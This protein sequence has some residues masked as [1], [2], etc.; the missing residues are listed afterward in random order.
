MREFPD[1][2]T[3]IHPKIHYQREIPLF[4]V[5]STSIG[6]FNL[7]NTVYFIF[8]HYSTSYLRNAL[9]FSYTYVIRRMTYTYVYVHVCVSVGNTY[10][11]EKCFAFLSL[12]IMWSTEAPPLSAFQADFTAID[13]MWS[14][15][16]PPL[17][18]FQADFTIR[19]LFCISLSAKLI[20][21]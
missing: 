16:A 21:G 14:T 4:W 8:Q 12:D 20:S 10:I 1:N 15:E 11:R 17:S 6:V 18:A 5:N 19:I 13:I 3:K 7:R 2:R 9:H